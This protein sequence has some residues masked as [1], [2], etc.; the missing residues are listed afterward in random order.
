MQMNPLT[1]TLRPTPARPLLGLTLLVVE[2]SRYAC[3]ALRLFALQSGARLRRA[4]RLSAARRHLGVYRP[5][6]MIVDIGLPDGSGL[7]LIREA[8]QAS[9]R[10]AVLLA[11]SGDPFTEDV[12]LAAGADGFLPK[13]VPGLAVFQSEIL[14]HLPRG[15]HPLGP[16]HVAQV[17]DRPDPEAFRDDVAHALSVLSEDPDAARIDYAARFVAG[18][19]ATAG[20]HA[21]GEAA[22]VLAGAGVS[23]APL[24]PGLTRLRSLLEDRLDRALAG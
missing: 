20:D 12:A 13:P 3:E 6:G 10:V 8:A 15:Q 18:L 4:D 1:P 9:P 14:A 17:L 23:G 22:E 7:E 16:R 21:L 2:D 19:A 11:T 5:S 24:G